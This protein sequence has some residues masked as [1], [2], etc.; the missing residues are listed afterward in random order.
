MKYAI[1]IGIFVIISLPF[2]AMAAGGT[3]IWEGTQCSATSQTGGPTESCNFCDILKVG[4][5]IIVSLTKIS[6]TVSVGMIV[7]GA[8]RMMVAGGSEGG[9]SAARQIMTNAAIGFV[10]TLAAWIVVNTILHLL[11]G[12][13][14]FPWNSV[15][16]I[17][18]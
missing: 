2:L 12:S 6:A 18:R 8:L 4:Q 9:V 1:I 13:I 15:V 3:G 10:I 16:C 5:N 17:M 11:S 14:S 7:Y